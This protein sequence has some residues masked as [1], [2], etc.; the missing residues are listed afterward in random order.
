MQI[1]N[2][3]IFFLLFLLMHFFVLKDI[4]TQK[5]ATSLML[6]GGNIEKKEALNKKKI[7][8]SRF[9]KILI[10]FFVL[11]SIFSFITKNMLLFGLILIIFVAYPIYIKTKSNEKDSIEF[12]EGFKIA[13]NLIKNQ[14]IAGSSL[15]QSIIQTSIELNTMN[16]ENS[17]RV[18]KTFQTTADELLMGV[19]L[20]DVLDHL[21]QLHS[22]E[23]VSD[24]VTV[25]LITQKRGGN[26]IEM[27]SS[28]E[29]HISTRITL[30]SE[31]RTLTASKRFESKIL[32]IFPFLMIIMLTVMS[33]EY[34]APLYN[35]ALG[36]VLLIFGVLLLAINYWIGS[37]IVRIEI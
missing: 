4:L 10:I 34:M 29:T 8:L 6:M 1:I 33:P 24:F 36:K 32:T 17:Q 15:K 23:V 7:V 19:P 20:R 28:L 31:I 37:K 26:L 13:V 27:L 25:I 2:F 12:E 18:V 14:L 11:G 16:I 5:K 22:S 3:I 21:T 9:N 35:T 30:R